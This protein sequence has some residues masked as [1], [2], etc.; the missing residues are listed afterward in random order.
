MVRDLME[1]NLDQLDA[2][3]ER[4]KEENPQAQD[5]I[6]RLMDSFEEAKDQAQASGR[7]FPTVE[8]LGELGVMMEQMMKTQPAPEPPEAPDEP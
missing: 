5:Q 6:E 4:L 3:V 8:N 1:G 7:P 2:M